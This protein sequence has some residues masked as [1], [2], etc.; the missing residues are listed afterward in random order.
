MGGSITTLLNVTTE[1]G[2]ATGIGDMYISIT[3]ASLSLTTVS[4][5]DWM[6]DIS[7]GITFP[8]TPTTITRTI[9]TRTL[10]RTI[11]TT[12]VITLQQLIVSRSKPFRR[13]YCNLAITMVPS[14]A[15]SD[16]RRATRW[17]DIRSP[18]S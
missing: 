17:Q 15:F 7:H 18:S 8:I 9:T 14:T 2:T 6:M 11:T 10:A 13:S 4:G 3:V 1:I 12:R 5:G 16:R